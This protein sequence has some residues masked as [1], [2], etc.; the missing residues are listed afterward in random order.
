MTMEHINGCRIYRQFIYASDSIELGFLAEDK[1]EYKMYGGFPTAL[2]PVFGEIFS[3][4]FL[5]DSRALTYI[6]NDLVMFESETDF[7]IAF[8]RSVPNKGQSWRF[9]PKNN[10]GSVLATPAGNFDGGM[11][12]IGDRRIYLDVGDVLEMPVQDSDGRP[13]P[14]KIEPITKGSMYLLT[15]HNLDIK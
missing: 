10:L 12:Q 9:W 7:N 4:T 8:M 11:F 1:L 13:I 6:I 14:F 2:A 15:L 3:Q 5:D